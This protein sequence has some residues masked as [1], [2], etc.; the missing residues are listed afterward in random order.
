MGG[1]GAGSWWVKP[2]HV[3][4]VGRDVFGGGCGLRTS[5]GLSAVDGAESPLLVVWPGAFQ[6][7]SLNPVVWDLGP[8]LGAKTATSRRAGTICPGPLPPVSFPLREL[9]L[10]PASPGRHS[11]GLQVTVPGAHGVTA[12]PGFPVLMKPCVPPPRVESLFPLWH[13]CSQ[14][15]LGFK[16]QMLLF[17][18]PDPQAG[19]P[20]PQ[21]GEPD[22]GLR[23]QSCGRAPGRCGI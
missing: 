23:T 10:T 20:D 14:A 15:P 8:G 19:E 17:P 16:S 13:S 1:T 6:H 4:L 5:G 11:R 3:P 9:Q 22:M 18:V 21:A 7:W 12:L 2:S